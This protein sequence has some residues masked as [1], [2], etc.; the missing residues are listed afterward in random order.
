MDFRKSTCVV[1]GAARGL[2]KAIATALVEQGAIVALVDLPDGPLRETTD[3][4]SA[5]GHVLSVVADI[6]VP[7]QVEEMAA[8]VEAELGA[9]DLL[10]NN[11]GTFSTIGPVWEVDPERWFRDVRTNLY[12]SFL[13][14]R[15]VVGGMVARKHGCVINVASSGGVGESCRVGDQGQ[16]AR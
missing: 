13:V 7:E 10:V 3:E 16:P 9:V 4:L 5:K 2:G 11:A 14:C 8:Q 6:T 12:G 15:A 1:T